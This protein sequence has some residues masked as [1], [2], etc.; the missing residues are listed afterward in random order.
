MKNNTMTKYDSIAYCKILEKGKFVYKKEYYVKGIKFDR[1]VVTKIIT[2]K[3]WN[4][5][6]NRIAKEC[7]I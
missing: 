6:Q 2:E 1:L 4:K 3:M 7:G 5:L